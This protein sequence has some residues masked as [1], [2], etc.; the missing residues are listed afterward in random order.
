MSGFVDDVTILAASGH[1]GAGAVSFRR[2]KY[3]PKGGPDGGDGGRGGDVRLVVRRDLRTLSHLALRRA[4]RAQRGESGQKR[5]RHGRDGSSVEI[6][7]PPGTIVSD[8]ESGEVLW[9]ALEEGAVHLLL[10]GG[11][12]G[13]GNAHFATSTHQAP[14][15]SQPGEPGQEIELRV[16][17]RLIA[18]VG[19]VGFPNAGK[20]SL[21]GR[22]TAAR[23]KVGNYRFTTKIPNLGV[24]MLG[25]EQVVLADLPGIIEGASG[26]AGLGVQFLRHISRTRAIALVIDLAEGDPLRTAELLVAELAAYGGGLAKKDRLYI[27]TKI[28]LPDTGAS[29]QTLTDEFG[30]DR[31]CAVSAVT[32]EGVRSL[33][34]RLYEVSRTAPA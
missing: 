21:L 9:E 14:R 27:G 7:V 4:Y 11:R 25:D 5:N 32:G 17:L 33:A 13:K 34:Q 26:G 12:G 28:D 15:F 6:P 31:V 8:S 1:G 20:S 22:L 10:H 3:I 30:S 24:M 2:E 19:F 23:P 29:L 18:D 16:E